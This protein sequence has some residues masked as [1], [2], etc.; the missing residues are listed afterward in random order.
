MSGNKSVS[1][2]DEDRERTGR[3]RS[4]TLPTL[5]TIPCGGIPMTR[6]LLITLLF[7]SS[8]PAYAEWVS[9][10]QDEVE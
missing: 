10:S 9:I 6:L 1:E 4:P 5:E 2:F 3:L 8:G 7:M